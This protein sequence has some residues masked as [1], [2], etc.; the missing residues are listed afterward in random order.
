M[1]L[2]RALALLLPV[3]CLLLAG[4]AAALE[5]VT[6]QLKWKHQFQFA[7]YYAAIS[8]GYYKAVG[9]DVN[10]L[11]ADE[12]VTPEDSVLSGRAQFGISGSDL[13]AYRAQ[14]KPIVVLASIFQHSPLVFLTSTQIHS[15]QDLTGKKVML[16]PHEAEL[17]AFLKH[18]GLSRDRLIPIPHSYDVTELVRGQVDAMSGYS[19]DQPF[20]LQQAR[21]SFHQFSPRSIGIDF[22]GDTLFVEE[23][24]LNQHTV[25]ATAFRDAS[26]KGWEYALAHP[27]EIID[28]IAKNY[29]SRS[30][31]EHL[32]FEATETARLIQSDLA[33]LGQTSLERWQ[34][35]ANIYAE[36]GLIPGNFSL[37]GFIFNAR[38]HKGLAWIQYALVL[39]V[40]LLFILAP[41]TWNFARLNRRMKAALKE[42]DQALMEGRE[43][44]E[45]L[46]VLLN[47]APV[48]VVVWKEGFIVTGWNLEAQ[49]TFGWSR[50]EVIGRNFMD[51]MVT[52]ENR[53]HVTDVTTTMLNV[54]ELTRS[55]DQNLT[56]SGKRIWCEWS[57]AMFRD[58][59]GKPAGVISIAVDITERRAAE[60]SLKMANDVLQSRLAEIEA[61]QA[62]LEEQAIRDGLTG[63]FNRRFLDETLEREVARAR[64][65][66]LPLSI[67]MLDV[68]HFKPLN[69][70]YGHR[71]GDEVLRTLAS[72]LKQDTRT[73][74]VACRY[75]GEEFLVLLPGMTHQKA[76]EKAEAW[77]QEIE[78]QQVRFGIHVLGI[79]ASFGVATFPDHGHDPDQLTAAADEALYRAKHL[80]RN[81]VVSYDLGK[82]LKLYAN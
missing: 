49:R 5:T 79:T 59:F 70:T 77:R 18:S 13:V 67:V 24:W 78:R 33:P 68:D 54:T 35:I 51:F 40:I 61:L 4:T 26:L 75:G 81:R 39:G 29:P 12:Q 64:R 38:D 69:D 30:S 28:L 9:L 21:F 41:L 52:E 55:V 1:R 53:V 31:R 80:G 32:R 58:S 82:Q 20:A 56:R 50:E 7:G 48:A 71:A 23:G 44:E 15:V 47:A 10:I 74:D 46:R 25:V 17:F 72:L 34:K 60:H 22:Y 65:E 3:L 16:L 6:L 57:N 73:G 36:S 63:L 37:D 66:G 62:E 19:T 14:G 42:R 8:Q 43:N 45:R 27:E 11:E 76:E 2:R